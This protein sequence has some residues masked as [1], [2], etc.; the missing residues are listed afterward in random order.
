MSY[1]GT[2]IAL[3]I[4]KSNTGISEGRPGETP[5]LSS[6]PFRKDH[7]G[8]LSADRRALKWIAMRLSVERDLT[9]VRVAIEAPMQHVPPGQG[10]IKTTL[11][12]YS[13]V[14]TVGAF[15]E[16]RGCMV[17]IHP[18]TTI[19][20]HFIQA[21]N[22]KSDDAKRAVRQRCLDLGWEP[23][24]FDQSDAAALWWFACR[25]WAPREAHIVDPTFL[26]A[27]GRVA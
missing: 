25:E 26:R 4:S 11:Q 3:D 17:A 12:L 16:E 7:D 2:V 13:L 27:K 18:P 23:E 24:N 8:I 5:R 19:R 21:G 15:A 22:L 6:L 20:K 1:T 14:M 10:N 9:M